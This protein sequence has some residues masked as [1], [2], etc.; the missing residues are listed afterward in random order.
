MSASIKKLLF[1]T[2]LSEHARH[3]FNF[4][5]GVAE[6]YGASI[7]IL[8]V[9]E[10]MPDAIEARL[11]GLLGPNKWKELKKQHEEEVMEILIGKRREKVIIEQALE[12]FAHEAK[13][14]NPECS[15]VTDEIIVKQGNIVDEIV[16]QAETSGADLIIMAYY[17]R[18]M[19]AEAMMRGVTRRVL[20]RSKRPVLLAPIP[21][22]P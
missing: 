18:S 20:R 3:A 6:R 12:N 15:V 10:D 16:A 19:I 21:E 8:H 7:S 2:D 1:P 5:A 9:M 22:N 17:A 14:D 13:M 11:A 4:A